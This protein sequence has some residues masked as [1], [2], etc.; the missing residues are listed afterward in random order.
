MILFTCSEVL[1]SIESSNSKV[2]GVLLL[3]NGTNQEV[4]NKHNLLQKGFSPEDK[5]PNRYSD[6]SSCPAQPWN[7]YGTN[8]LLENWSFPIFVIYNQTSI[9]EIKDVRMIVTK[10]NIFLQALISEKIVLFKNLCLV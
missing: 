7:P 5:C 10:F 1:K 2:N 3:M 6:S 8:I 9:N 4:I